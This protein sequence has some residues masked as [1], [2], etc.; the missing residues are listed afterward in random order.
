M[1]N[2]SA[3][4]KEQ[5]MVR[6]PSSSA[7]LRG[8]ARSTAV[9]ALSFIALAL[10]S[11]GGS[12]GRTNSLGNGVGLVG[13]DGS[14]TTVPAGLPADWHDSAV[15]AAKSALMKCAQAASLSPSGCPQSIADYG[16]TEGV[17]WKLLGEPL[18]HA[19]ASPQASAFNAGE[20]GVTVSGLYQMEV[21][22]TTAGQSIRPYLDLVGGVATANMTWD[23]T[24]FQKV[25]FGIAGFG[26]A[27][28]PPFARPV[29]ATDEAALA[30]VRDAFRA[31]FHL[32]PPPTDP[33]IPNCPQNETT[34]PNTTTASWTLIGDPLQGALV[35]FDPQHGN[36]VVTGNYAA[37]LH[38]E[39][40]IPGNPY[41]YNTGSH[42]KSHRGSYTAT[43]AWNGQGIDL[44]KVV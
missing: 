19:V 34:D 22:Y 43:L 27:T 33:S 3:P 29:G 6:H 28:V 39:V 24:S 23:G 4:R 15:R 10:A 32:P 13:P 1:R 40:K 2:E 7:R 38:Y 31:C 42:T 26:D 30:A 25:Q 41:Y 17:A 18:D 8:V 5:D 21:S 36:V 11:C 20:P 12:S 9:L 37:E 14:T 16:N 35:S 44:I